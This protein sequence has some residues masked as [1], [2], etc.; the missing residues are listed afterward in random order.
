MTVFLFF[1]TESSN[2]SIKTNTDPYF[3]GP[4]QDHSIRIVSKTKVYVVRLDG[5]HNIEALH[6]SDVTLFKCD[7]KVDESPLSD[8]Y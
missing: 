1:S 7:V 2:G 5:M 3:I 4:G 6:N 8:F